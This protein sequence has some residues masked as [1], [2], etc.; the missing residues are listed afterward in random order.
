MEAGNAFSAGDVLASIETDKAVVDYEAT[1]DGFLA[2]ILQPAGIEIQ[3]GV[4]ICVVVEE[5]GD[6]AAFADYEPAAAAAAVS[7][8]PSPPSP[9]TAATAI[10]VPQTHPT[11]PAE[12]IL[13]PAARHMSHSAGVDATVLFPGSGLK[14]RVTKSDIVLAMKAGQTL[15]PLATTHAAPPAAVAT[16][17]TPVS[18]AAAPLPPSTATPTITTTS[19][20]TDTPA[21]GMRKIIGS[22]LTQ[23]KSTVPHMY[24]TQAIDVTGVA[25]FRKDLLTSMGVK[26]SVNDLVIAACARALRDFPTVNGGTGPADISVAVASKA[27]LITP[28]VTDANA[29]GLSNLSATVRELAGR[30]REG[31]L[32]PEEYQGGNFT[33]SNL[34]MMGIDEFTAVI[35]PP[36]GTILAVSS[37]VSKLVPGETMSDAPRLVT[38]MMTTLSADRNQVDEATAAAFLQAVAVYLANPKLLVL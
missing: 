10:P 6:M 25:A 21:S 28:I 1:D 7:D 34:G 17:P 22:R 13:T 19:T 20:Y 12:F 38:E 11:L 30:A 26:V 32:Q 15:P 9:V 31:K 4:E 33:I 36:Q 14:G 27:G 29:R 5:E 23:S 18:A 8:A 37:G 35:N 2:K 16:T 24:A 3:C